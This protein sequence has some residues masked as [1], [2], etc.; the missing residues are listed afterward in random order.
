MKYNKNFTLKT[1]DTVLLLGVLGIIVYQLYITFQ[2][3]QNIFED[4]R[5]YIGA[6]YGKDYITAY[7]ERFVEIKKMFT[8]PTKIGFF[9]EENEEQTSFWTHYYLTQYYLAP[10][11][12][13]KNTPNCDTILYNRHTTKQIDISTNFHINNGWHILKDFNNGLIVLAK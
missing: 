3:K 11:L 7:E 5:A 8:K 13:I 12:I 2:T 9:G 6:N 4:P 10:N 1:I